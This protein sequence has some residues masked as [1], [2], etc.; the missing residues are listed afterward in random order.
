MTIMAVIW[1]GY[2]QGIRLKM[3]LC[4]AFQTDSIV[5]DSNKMELT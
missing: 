3:H 5:I 1:D 4:K 2:E